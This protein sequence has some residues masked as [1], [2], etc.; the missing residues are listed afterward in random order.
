[1]PCPQLSMTSATQDSVTRAGD[2]RSTRFDHGFPPDRRWWCDIVQY[3]NGQVLDFDSTARNER[4]LWYS[5]LAVRYPS[6]EEF[7]LELG[8]VAI[9]R[10]TLF[11]PSRGLQRP[12]ADHGMLLSG[13]RSIVQ[14]DRRQ[15]AVTY[16]FTAR[17][18]LYFN[19]RAEQK[20]A[21][22]DSI[23]GVCTSWYSSEVPG[24]VGVR[25]DAEHM[26]LPPA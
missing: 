20:V 24:F 19:H 1:M 7:V 17:Q 21:V 12:E 4:E 25:D 8:R 9:A 10:S 22:Q 6:E 18:D 26:L 5:V 13:N 11:E 16:Q 3:P 15:D 23:Y 14:T 2:K